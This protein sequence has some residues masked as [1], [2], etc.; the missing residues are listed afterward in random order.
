MIAIDYAYRARPV[1][2]LRRCAYTI[3]QWLGSAIG[4]LTLLVLLHYVLFWIAGGR[5]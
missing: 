1:H 5:A 3:G 2:P 4:G